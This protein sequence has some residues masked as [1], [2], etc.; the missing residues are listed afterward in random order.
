[1]KICFFAGE[2]QVGLANLRVFNEPNHYENTGQLCA[3]LVDVPELF[4]DHVFTLDYA[5]NQGQFSSE[6]YIDFDGTFDWDWPESHTCKQYRYK[7]EMTSLNELEK[8]FVNSL[9]MIKK[10]R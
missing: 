3:E 9:E 7:A 10:G 2:K 5:L 1:M 8:E 4:Q 6:F